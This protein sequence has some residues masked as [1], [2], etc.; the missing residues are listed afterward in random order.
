[1]VSFHSAPQEPCSREYESAKHQ[2][3]YAGPSLAALPS[4]AERL[5]SG[6]L[7][8]YIAPIPAGP[9]AAAA[10]AGL[11]IDRETDLELKG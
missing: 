4:Y 5:S 1:M 10:A 2:Q 6:Y 9:A 3:I 8:P 11:S 7:Q